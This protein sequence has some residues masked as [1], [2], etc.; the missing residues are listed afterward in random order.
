[1]IVVRITSHV[2][3]VV[4]I[5]VRITVVSRIMSCWIFVMLCKSRGKINR[6]VVI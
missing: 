6:L 2:L 4:V 5:I 3:V 1:M